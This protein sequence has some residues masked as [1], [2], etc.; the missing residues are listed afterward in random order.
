MFRILIESY[1]QFGSQI[2]LLSCVEKKDCHFQFQQNLY[3]G[4]GVFFFDYTESDSKSGLLDYKRELLS[5]LCFDQEAEGDHEEEE[6]AHEVETV[7]NAHHGGLDIDDLI[8]K[9]TGV[10]SFKS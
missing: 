2:A 8:E 3:L 5:C 4:Y 1:N 10:L 7:I 6:K 9:G